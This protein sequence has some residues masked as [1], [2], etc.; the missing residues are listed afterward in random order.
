MNI[1]LTLHHNW[2]NQTGSYAPRLRFGKAHVLNNLV[3]RWRTAAAAC[4]MG[5]EIYS[6]GN[7]FIAKDDKQA[8]ATS[9]GSDTVKGRAKSIGDW[10]QNGAV[11]A[12]DDAD[13]V[14]QP[15]TFY[16]YTAARA[17]AALDAAIRAGAGAH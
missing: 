5:G 4:T 2:W 16:S 10:L 6:E 9:A 12:Q 3:D 7:V 8:L 17:D 1:R 14:F 15:W 11:V 13:L